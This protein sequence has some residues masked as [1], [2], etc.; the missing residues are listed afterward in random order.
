MS[1]ISFKPHGKLYND[2]YVHIVMAVSRFDNEHI[3]LDKVV[4]IDVCHSSID[5]Y[6][7]EARDL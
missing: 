2:L 7:D 1:G 4:D 6:A 3:A 5:K